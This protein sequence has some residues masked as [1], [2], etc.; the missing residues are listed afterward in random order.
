MNNAHQFLQEHMKQLITKNYKQIELT[1]GKSLGKNVFDASMSK[2]IFESLKQYFEGTEESTIQELENKIYYEDNKELHV[3]S[4]YQDGVFKSQQRVYKLSLYDHLIVK[5]PKM[6]LDIKYTFSERKMVSIEHFP[7]RRIYS[8]EN[9]KRVTSI[10]IK[11]KFYLNFNEF[12][13]IDGTIIYTVTMLIKRRT[14][15]KHNELHNMIKNFI[16]Q[17]Q[18]VVSL[19]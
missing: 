9:F 8:N 6:P 15:N 4:T 5:S 19:Q 14:N 13:N 7:T 3:N 16:E 17:I 18:S 11:N 10:N 12:Q 2:N 1:F